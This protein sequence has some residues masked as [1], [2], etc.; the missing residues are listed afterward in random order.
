MRTLPTKGEQAKSQGTNH[1]RRATSEVVHSEAI[2]S[3]PV[4]NRGGENR[5]LRRSKRC[6]LGAPIPTRNQCTNDSGTPDGQRGGSQPQP[7]GQLPTEELAY[8]AQ[9][10]LP[11]LASTD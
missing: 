10:S 8:R 6:G 3:S 1:P 4:N 9:V 11:T 2:G 5:I 7:G